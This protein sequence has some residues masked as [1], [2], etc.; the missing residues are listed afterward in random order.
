MFLPRSQSSP[1][2]VSRR[3]PTSKPCVRSARVVHSVGVRAW[4]V[5]LVS[6]LAAAGARAEADP[7]TPAVPRRRVLSAERLFGFAYATRSIDGTPALSP[8]E[9][10]G[11][12]AGPLGAGA[13]TARF[14]VPRLALDV[15]VAGRF[16]VG[17]GLTYFRATS[18]QTLTAFSAAL[19]PTTSDT[20]VLA[21]RV[22]YLIPLARSVSVWPRVGFTYLLAHRTGPAMDFGTVAVHETFGFYA[23]TIEAPITI[24]IV[25]HFL[26]MAGPTLDLGLKGATSR[27]S[28]A[29]PA[30]P[31][32]GTRES[33][34]GLMCGLGGDF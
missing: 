34:L 20:L 9:E 29:G 23:L 2:P 30:I 17:G 18:H 28:D 3:G 14:A 5:L 25:D 31:N 15:F 7:S 13:P 19:S 16:S 1:D 12:A 6:F 10:T 4:L 24:R 21:P 22:G 27:Q 11:T 26:L 33:D 8:I 32:R